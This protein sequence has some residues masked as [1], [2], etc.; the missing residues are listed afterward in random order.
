MHDDLVNN[1][2]YQLERLPELTLQ[3]STERLGIPL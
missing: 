3:S 2:S 1:K